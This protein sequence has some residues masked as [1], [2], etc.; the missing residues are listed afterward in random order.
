MAGTVSYGM[1]QIRYVDNGVYTTTSAISPYSIEST[2]VS[3][4]ATYQDILLFKEAG[5][6]NLG[7]PYYLRLGIPRNLSYDL[8]FDLKLLVSRNTETKPTPINRSQYQEIKRIV[9]P[10]D[11]SGISTYSRVILFPEGGVNKNNSPIVKIVR[12]IENREDIQSIPN[13]EVYCLF[14]QQVINNKKVI[15]VTYY[16]RNTQGQDTEILFKNDQ[17]LNHTWKSGQ[18][19]GIEYIDLIF[20]NKVEGQSFNSILLEMVRQDYD[21]DISYQG[22]DGKTYNGLYIDP[23]D[24]VVECYELTNLVPTGSKFSSIGVW[25][26]P[27]AIMAINGEEIRIGQSSYYELNDFDITNF[28][29]VVRKDINGNNNPKDR[30]SLDY[31]YK[32]I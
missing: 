25:S 5:I 17:L 8:T 13:G 20:S 3:E 1:G 11:S 15:K 2:S 16:I 28:G 29:I 10:R 12:E 31:Q 30:F 21:N 9:I 6:F 22:T 27:N 18:D 26:H 7:Q 23:E 32:V 14:E 24:I 19:G 4:A